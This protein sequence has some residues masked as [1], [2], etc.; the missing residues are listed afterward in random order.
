[1]RLLKKVEKLPVNVGHETGASLQLALH[2]NFVKLAR[3]LIPSPSLLDC[4]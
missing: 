2:H 3:R 1:M 4:E